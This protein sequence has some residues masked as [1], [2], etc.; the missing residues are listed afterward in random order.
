ML[1]E[2]LVEKYSCVVCNR[3]EQV[4]NISIGD[5]HLG[6]I[7]YSS[8]VDRGEI[9]DTDVSFELNFA[10][11]GGQIEKFKKAIQNLVNEYAI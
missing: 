10:I 2:H 8:M 7:N 3:R 9:L 1:C 5:F 11:A 6:N 4:Q